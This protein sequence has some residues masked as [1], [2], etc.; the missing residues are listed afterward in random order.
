MVVPV[1]IEGSSA[2]RFGYLAADTQALFPKVKVTI[3]RR[4]SCS[5]RR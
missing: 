3:C 2:R 1:R 5:A 4:S